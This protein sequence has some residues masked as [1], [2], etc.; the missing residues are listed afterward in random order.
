MLI[1]SYQR[2]DKLTTFLTHCGFTKVSQH[3]VHG[4]RAKGPEDNL[5]L[6]RRVDAKRSSAPVP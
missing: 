1:R 3:K 4:Q 6:Y 2:T 5:V